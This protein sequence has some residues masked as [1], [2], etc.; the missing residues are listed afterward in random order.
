MSVGFGET[1]AH[2]RI[3]RQS[4]WLIFWRIYKN[5]SLLKVEKILKNIHSNRDGVQCCDQ[6][7]N[8]FLLNLPAHRGSNGHEASLVMKSQGWMSHV[9][10]NLDVPA[11]QRV[12]L[13][14]GERKD[15]SHRT[16]KTFLHPLNTFTS[17]GCSETNV[18]IAMYVGIF[19]RYFLYFFF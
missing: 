1:G 10:S 12:I 8:L 19:A 13:P 2:S 17:T 16:F 11:S 9:C 4:K 5:H 15:E 3:E 7:L 6:E 18:K 14:R